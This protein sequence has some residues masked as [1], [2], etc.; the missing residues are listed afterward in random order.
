MRLFSY[1]FSSLL[2]SCKTWR[3][4]YSV[5]SEGS[6]L[7]RLDIMTSEGSADLRLHRG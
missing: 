4:S 5:L 2:S 6:Q 3:L 7:G 1:S